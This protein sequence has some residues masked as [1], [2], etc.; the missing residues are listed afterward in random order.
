M[1]VGVS[2]P[3]LFFLDLRS[4]LVMVGVLIGYT[5]P[6]IDRIMVPAS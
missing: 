4:M 5:G 6:D 2:F 3:S 1:V